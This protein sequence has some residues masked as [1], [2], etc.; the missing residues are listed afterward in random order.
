MMNL[1]VTIVGVGAG[2][3]YDEAGPTHWAVEDLSVMRCLPNMV[4]LNASDSDE[5]IFFAEV[6]CETR[7]PV[8]VRVDRKVLPDTELSHKRPDGR[9]TAIP[10]CADMLIIATGNM[11]QRAVE[12]AEELNVGALEIYEFPITWD[13]IDENIDGIK[14]I[15]TLE[16]HTLPGGLGSAVLEVLSDNNIKIPVKRI[17]MDFSKG[18]CYQYGRESIQKHYGLDKESIIKAIKGE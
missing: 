11:F 8:Y 18:Y 13:R 4:I 6:T 16:E 2:V 7:Y 17:G 3:S 15:I 1:P 5:A 9:L 10:I 14:Q 12:V